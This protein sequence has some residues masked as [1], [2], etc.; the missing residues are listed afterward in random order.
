MLLLHLILV[1]EMLS[2]RSNFQ[3]VLWNFCRLS[4]KKKRLTLKENPYF[5]AELPTLLKA[6][7]GESFWNSIKIDPTEDFRRG[8]KFYVLTDK[9]ELI[10]IMT[11]NKILQ[12]FGNLWHS[13]NEV[14]LKGLGILFFPP[15]F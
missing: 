8:D 15:C 13:E 6:Y 11:G 12:S 1:P 10:H 2:D 9:Q 7:N 14:I 5:Y 3:E 4:D